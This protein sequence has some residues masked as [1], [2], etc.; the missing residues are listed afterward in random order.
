MAEMKPALHT[1]W[2]SVPLC[3]PAWPPTYSLPLRDLRLWPRTQ[4]KTVSDG[5]SSAGTALPH[6]VEGRT[7]QQ[8]SIN[9][10]QQ[11]VRY[12]ELWTRVPD[13]S[14]W[15]VEYEC[16]HFGILHHVCPKG[17]F[18]SQS[19]AAGAIN[20]KDVYVIFR[21]IGKGNAETFSGLEMLR[22]FMSDHLFGWNHLSWEPDVHA[23][24]MF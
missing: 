6:Y 13:F 10:N 3:S 8:L 19:L 7:W 20:L 18:Q 21:P 14:S 4:G 23:L 2:Y 22:I 24:Y 12:E 11:A 5:N 17:F 16:L 15:C 1:F 9:K